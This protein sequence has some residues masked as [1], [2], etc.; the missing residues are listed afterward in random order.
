MD[1]KENEGFFFSYEVTGKQIKKEYP[2]N[3][4]CPLL[5]TP[6]ANVRANNG[7]INQITFQKIFIV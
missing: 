2:Q 7:R 6:H 3:D 5:C 4:G 1:K